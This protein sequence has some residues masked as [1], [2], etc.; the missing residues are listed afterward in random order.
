MLEAPEDRTSTQ[1][2]LQNSCL[3]QT[4]KLLITYRGWLAR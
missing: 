2:L 1:Q 4:R 3:H